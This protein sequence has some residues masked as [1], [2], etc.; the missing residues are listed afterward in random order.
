MLAVLS[1]LAILWAIFNG[2]QLGHV[3][4]IRYPNLTWNKRFGPQV[5]LWYFNISG[6]CAFAGVW[7]LYTTYF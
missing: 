7:Y 6:L 4:G 5:W 2:S 3:G 1:I